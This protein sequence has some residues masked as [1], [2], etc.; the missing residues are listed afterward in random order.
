MCMWQ[1]TSWW[2]VIT[3]VSSGILALGII[4]VICQ[5]CMLRKQMS[6]SAFNSLLEQWGGENEREARRHV[7]TEFEFREK[8][9][10][11]NLSDESRRKVELVLATC[12]RTSFLAL[13]GFISE[14][15]VLEF[16]GY[17]MVRYWDKTESFIKARRRQANQPEEGKLGSY[18]YSLQQFVTRNRKKLDA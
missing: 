12:D 2:D 15:A 8:D 10:L 1:V 5:V 17:P 6:L 3:S 16:V 18:I 7:I 14:K 9:D 11:K 4:A 13:K